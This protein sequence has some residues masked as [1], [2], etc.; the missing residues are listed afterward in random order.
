MEPRSGRI[1]QELVEHGDE[2]VRS[3]ARERQRGVN[4]AARVVGSA[5]LLGEAVRVMAECQ[6]GRELSAPDVDDIVAFLESL[7]GEYRGRSL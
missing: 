4:A 7:T 3:I 2:N 6:L 5:P 1:P